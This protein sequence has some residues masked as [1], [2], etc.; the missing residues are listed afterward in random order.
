MELNMYYVDVVVGSD[1]NVVLKRVK[2]ASDSAANALA[3][4]MEDD[5][6][7]TESESDPVD[8]I[9]VGIS[10]AET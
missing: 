1:S 2:V 4:V 3:S 8:K 10:L 6:G 9:A 5:A 7:I